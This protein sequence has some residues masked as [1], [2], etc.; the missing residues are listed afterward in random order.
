[1]PVALAGPVAGRQVHE[2][3]AEI[4]EAAGVAEALADAAGAGRRERGGVADA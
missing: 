3:H 4:G 2:V 1:M